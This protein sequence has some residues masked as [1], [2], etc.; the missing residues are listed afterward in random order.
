MV[1]PVN[2]SVGA[3][4][5]DQVQ[6]QEVDTGIRSTP[7]GSGFSQL[8]ATEPVSHSVLTLTQP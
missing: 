7:V 4:N 5:G 6:P 3:E 2:G 8:R 1:Q